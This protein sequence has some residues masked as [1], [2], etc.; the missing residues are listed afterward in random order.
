MR[1]ARAVLALVSLVAGGCAESAAPR[2][3]ALVVIDTDLPSPR[4]A[5][6]L[7][8]TVLADVAGRL[9]PACDG[10]V[11]EV[12]VDSPEDW[13]FSFGV[14][15]P[16]DG[17]VRFVRA[18][19]FLAGRTSGGEIAEP[20]AVD[21]IVRLAFGDGVAAQEI[22]LGGACAAIG[23][24]LDERRSCSD[25]ALADVA[26]APLRDPTAPSLVGSY[27][28]SFERTCAGSPRADGGY[29][30]E[31]VCVPGGTFFM[32][33]VRRQGLG[34]DSDAVPEHLVTVSPFY[35]DRYEYTVGRYRAALRDG[36]VPSLGPADHTFNPDCSYRGPFDPSNDE[37]PLTCVPR[38]TAEE[39][40]A[41]EGAQL[42]T[43]AQWEWAGGSGAEERFYPWGVRRTDAETI[44]SGPDPVGTHAFD[45]TAHGVMDMGWN[46]TEL[47]A[48][49]FQ[50]Y[51]EEC[52]APGSY[53]PD[54]SC[55][56]ADGGTAHGQAARGG[57]WILDG[58]EGAALKPI[59]ANRQRFPPTGIA[60]AI[61]FR[62]LRPG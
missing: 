19:A 61:G 55:V 58:D 3:Q 52:W 13:P 39:I 56:P 14:A 31:T 54:P 21:A 12:A 16:D 62:C 37:L 1:L 18:T 59:A 51:T 47:V 33:D 28:A 44:L 26:D 48:D 20:T 49:W 60:H 23:A 29:F 34:E 7:R 5:D 40:C 32:G 36:L 8:I 11:R 15:R 24:R 35:L 17:S 10:C 45:V 42:P 53:G 4:L 46:V 38:D 6:R 2:S 43:E 57:Y 22:F 27:R 41:F 30:D 50:T 25:G 9:E